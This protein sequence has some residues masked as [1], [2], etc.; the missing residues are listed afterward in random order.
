MTFAYLTTEVLPDAPARSCCRRCADCSG[1]GT[2]LD[3]AGAR[4]GADRVLVRSR[5]PV[6]SR[7]APRNRRRCRHRSSCGRACVGSRL[8]CGQRPGRGEDR[9]RPDRRRV[10]GDA[11][12]P[13]L[14]RRAARR[15]RERRGS[16]RDRRAERGAGAGCAL[17]LPRDPHHGRRAGLPR[18][19]ALPARLER[20]FRRTARRGRGWGR[21]AACSRACVRAALRR[22]RRGARGSRPAHPAER[23][24][25]A[26]ATAASPSWAAHDAATAHVH[27]QRGG[28]SGCNVRAGPWP[29]ACGCGSVGASRACVKP[30]KVASRNGH[31]RGRA[32]ASARAGPRVD[33][34]SRAFGRPSPGGH[35]RDT[36]TGA[37]PR[38]NGL[39]ARPAPPSSRHEGAEG[40]SYH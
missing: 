7:P 19:V 24:D 13:R 40:R 4:P 39:T 8:V 22:A 16:D 21:C 2:R 37:A 20:R 14:L 26:T 18:P 25:Q 11:G 36:R 5:E 27:A 10:L 6:C 38:R 9:H 34:A 12:A 32:A 15:G 23:A 28:A 31:G 33:G 1:H 17:R 3:L 35:R 30:V 29:E